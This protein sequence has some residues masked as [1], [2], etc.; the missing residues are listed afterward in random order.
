MYIVSRSSASRHL[1][2]HNGEASCLVFGP[3]ENRAVVATEQIPRTV[4]QVA[5]GTMAVWHP[6]IRPNLAQSCQ[7]PTDINCSVVH[8]LGAGQATFRMRQFAWVNEFRTPTVMREGSAAANVGAYLGLHLRWSHDHR[9]PSSIC[10][11]SVPPFRF[12]MTSCG[13]DRSLAQG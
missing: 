12:F 2:H 4:A 13:E 6:E 3:P 8:G 5:S 7:S 9:T 1:M 10:N 11:S